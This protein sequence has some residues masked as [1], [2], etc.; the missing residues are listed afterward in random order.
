VLCRAVQFVLQSRPGSLY[1]SMVE[2]DA[3]T[4]SS[5]SQKPSS[6]STGDAAAYLDML[7]LLLLPL[8]VPMMVVQADLP[9]HLEVQQHKHSLHAAAR[10]TAIEPFFG[11]VGFP[12]TDLSSCSTDATEEGDD[13]A[14]AE[15][16]D[17]DAQ[18]MDGPTAS[19]VD[20]GSGMSLD[21]SL[22]EDGLS[23]ASHINSMR[24][25]LGDDA[26]AGASALAELSAPVPSVVYQQQRQARRSAGSWLLRARSRP[27]RS[28]L[29]R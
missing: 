25:G 8:R 12:S 23:E 5:R 24:A 11:N 20:I 9:A 10:N 14:E 3:A 15:S 13:S 29:N 26:E 16:G 27:S 18:E 22:V 6:T 7:Q 28:V 4:S 21:Q 19:T 1:I 17:D 2:G